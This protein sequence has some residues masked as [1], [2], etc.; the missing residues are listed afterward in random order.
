MIKE[1]KLDNFKSI[2]QEKDF[3]FRP[4]WRVNQWE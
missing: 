3:E 2:D 1:W 4:Y